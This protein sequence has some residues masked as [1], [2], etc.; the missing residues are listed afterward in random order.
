[1]IGKLQ[2]GMAVI[3]IDEENGWTFTTRQVRPSTSQ[4]GEIECG[5]RF[6]QKDKF[7]FDGIPVFHTVEV[8]RNGGFVAAFDFRFNAVACQIEF[9]SHG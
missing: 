4:T 7:R 1:M 6:F 3:A 9:N 5:E 8:A 2:A